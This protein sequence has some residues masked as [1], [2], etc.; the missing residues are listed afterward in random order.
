MRIKNMACEWYQELTDYFE[1]CC[2]LEAKEWETL[3]LQRAAKKISSSLPILQSQARV[4]SRNE[5]YKVILS[6]ARERQFNEA[7]IFFLHNAGGSGSHWLQGMLLER[8]MAQA[9]GEV[10]FVAPMKR[11]IRHLPSDEIGIALNV[12]HLLHLKE[13]NLNSLFMPMVNSS[14]MA[15]WN[16][17]DLY[18]KN[19]KNILLLR[20]PV[21]ILL[22]RTLRKQSYKEFVA[23]DE[24]EEEYFLRNV[25]F[26]KNFYR[27]ARGRNYDYI[28]KYE[29]IVADEENVVSKLTSLIHPSTE[30][31]GLVK[32]E[33]VPKGFNNKYKGERIN[34]MELVDKARN[35]LSEEISLF[36]STKSGLHQNFN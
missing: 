9:C 23:P 29:D 25:D 28:V 18:A 36:T 4:A 26:V 10:K 14:H 19:K 20:N 30:N 32:S 1:L 35:L 16:V 21:D 11:I 31:I 6:I 8:E 13:I 33:N 34:S 7:K 3:S 2:T 15:G 27:A 17:S 5:F 22:S 12:I 24:S